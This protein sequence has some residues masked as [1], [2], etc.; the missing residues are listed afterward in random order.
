MREQQEQS[1]TW[2]APAGR[3]PDLP[4]AFTAGGGR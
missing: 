4:A 1:V 3:H 2:A